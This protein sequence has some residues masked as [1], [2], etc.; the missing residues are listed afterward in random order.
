MT[1][2]TF[3][4]P[5]SCCLCPFLAAFWMWELSHHV[6]ARSQTCICTLSCFCPTLHA[7]TCA[8]AFQRGAPTSWFLIN[9][10]SSPHGAV[11]G[12]SPL[13]SCAQSGFPS[14]CFVIL[15]LCLV[16]CTLLPTQ[17]TTS[18]MDCGSPS[19][20]TP[21]FLASRSCQEALL[22]VCWQRYFCLNPPQSYFLE[23]T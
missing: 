5:C 7:C 2:T 12:T 23:S 16:C 18:P 3:P 15:K 10:E 8:K 6:C 4:I 21:S 20:F 22:P 17:P 19:L 14:P 11:C 1:P 9:Y 13:P